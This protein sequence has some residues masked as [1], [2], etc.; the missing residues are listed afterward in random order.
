[1]RYI[2]V[3]PGAKFTGLAVLGHDRNFSR[4]V[5]IPYERTQDV[6][7]IIAFEVMYDRNTVVILE[8]LIGSGQRDVHIIRTIK[9]VGY[10]YWSCIE[11]DITVDLV[12]NQARLANV[13]NVPSEITGKDE[14]AAAAHALTALE[15]GIGE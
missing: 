15:R 11:E 4:H 5:E 6:W 8:D 12:P 14:I 1:M 3:D 9:V 10:I 2:G 7:R 13:R